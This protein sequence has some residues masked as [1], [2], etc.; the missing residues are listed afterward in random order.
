MVKKKTDRED[1]IRGDRGSD[2][3]DNMK[4]R[5]MASDTKAETRNQSGKEVQETTEAEAEA[6]SVTESSADDGLKEKLAEMQ[7]RYLRLSA[8][9]DNYRKRTLKEK[10][11]LTRTASESVLVKLL[12]VIDDFERGLK[13]M[14]EASDCNAMKEGIKLIYSKFQAFLDQNGIKEIDAM[15]KPFNVD[16]HEAVTN[17]PAPEEKMKG[18]VIDVVE[19]GYLLTDK[20]IRFSKVVVGE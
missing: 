14:D 7:D 1:N 5:G 17:L 10:I 16:M 19:K 11:E 6:G 15:N 18:I 4:D 2:G 12:P 9:F 8:E 20:V 3:H 13:V